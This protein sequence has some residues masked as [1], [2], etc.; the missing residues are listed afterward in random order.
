MKK[1][2]PLFA[3]AAFA[4]ACASAQDPKP[5]SCP[6]PPKDLVT[7]DITKGDGE[8]VAFRTAITVSYTGWLYDGCAKDFKGAMFDTSD[9]RPTPFGFIVGAGRVIKGWDEGIIGMQR[10]GKRVLVIPADRAYG[11]KSPTPKI[12]P[13]SALVFEVTVQN[14]LASAS[15]PPSLQMSNPKK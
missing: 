14:I 4:A 3:V 7:T 12:P 11:A 2:Y 13:N 5:A 10:G 1:I 6:P 15:A 8:V 9:G